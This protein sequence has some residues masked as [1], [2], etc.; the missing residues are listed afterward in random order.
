MEKKKRTND[1]KAHDLHANSAEDLGIHRERGK[2]VPHKAHSG[3]EDDVVVVLANGRFPDDA[4][5]DG[6]L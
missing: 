1:E 5:N 3:V 6:G 4:R 2:V